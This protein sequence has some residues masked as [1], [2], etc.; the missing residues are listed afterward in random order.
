MAGA[1]LSTVLRH[2]RPLLVYHGT[3]RRFDRF[4]LRWSEEGE[5]GIFFTPVS[6][7][8]GASPAATAA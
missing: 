5:E 8:P 4:D 2:G 1:N 6:P 7:T 3:R